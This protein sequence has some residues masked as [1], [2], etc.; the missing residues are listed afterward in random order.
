LVDPGKRSE[1]LL[2]VEENARL[3]LGVLGAHDRSLLERHVD[4]RL[5]YQEGS[6]RIALV[7]RVEQSGYLCPRPDAV[8]LNGRDHQRTVEQLLARTDGCGLTNPHYS[9]PPRV[10]SRQPSTPVLGHDRRPADQMNI[11]QVDHR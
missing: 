10:N 7:E 11:G 1:T 5:P 2:T 6:D 4:V 9:S 8:P 3:G